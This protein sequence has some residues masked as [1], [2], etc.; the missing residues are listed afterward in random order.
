MAIKEF[1]PVDEADEY[2]LLAV[3]G[4][5]EVPSLLL[6]YSSGIFPWPLSADESLLWFSPAERAL[7]FVDEFP[8]SLFCLTRNHFPL[9]WFLFQ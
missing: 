5:L 8:R 4:D 9:S 2:G 7:L 1:P 3:G 6:A